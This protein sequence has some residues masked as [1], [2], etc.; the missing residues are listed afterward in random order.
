[1]AAVTALP[2]GLERRY[3]SAVGTVAHVVDVQRLA[4]G[5]GTA[6]K[7][8]KWPDN[9]GWRGTGS[10]AERERAAALPLCKTCDRLTP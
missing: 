2:M 7:C 4:Q 6:A 5:R 1:M 3:L 10:Q 9:L 8:G